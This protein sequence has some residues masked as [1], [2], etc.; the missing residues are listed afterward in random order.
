MNDSYPQHD[1]LFPSDVMQKAPQA[2]A[3]GALV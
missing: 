1:D 3:R 2:V